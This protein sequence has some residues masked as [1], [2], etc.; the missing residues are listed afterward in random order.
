MKRKRAL[1]TALIIAGVVL[2]LV[3]Y[4]IRGNVSSRCI[5][6]LMG[7]AAGMIGIGV[8]QLCSL[9]MEAADPSLRRRNRIEQGDERNVAIRN[10]A[11]ALSGDTLQWAVIV[12]SWMAFGLGG[13]AWI[14][15]LA[16]ASL[17]VK[18]L[19][20]LWLT[21]RYQKEM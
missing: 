8:S 7:L 13:P 3:V 2:I 16:L 1:Y 5:I 18:C 19:L 11:K 20:E 9:G 17:I 10:R 14:I 6:A 4:L 15:L 21:V 12:A